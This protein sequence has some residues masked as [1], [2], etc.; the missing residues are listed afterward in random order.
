MGYELRAG[1]IH[2]GH[3]VKYFF[4]SRSKYRFV[5]NSVKLIYV[6]ENDLATSQFLHEY[7]YSPKNEHYKSFLL[8]WIR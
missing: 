8:L 7:F 4:K 2:E 1:M 3:I 6:Q 5:R